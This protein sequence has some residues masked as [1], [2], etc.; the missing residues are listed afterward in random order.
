MKENESVADFNSRT[1]NV[2]NQLKSNGEDYQEQR[3]VE[4]ILRSLPHKYDNLV[5]TIEEAKDLTT[6]KMDELMGS[7]QTH[8]HRI[9]RSTSSSTQEQAFK[10]QSNSKGRGRGRNGSGR[11]SRGRGRGNG[12]QR[13]IAAEISGRAD[14][15]SSSQNTSRGGKKNYNSNMRNVECYYCH[16]Y[17][18]YASDC[19]K[20]QSDQ[21]RQANVAD[22][23]HDAAFI[24]C[25]VGEE[26]SPEV[27]YLDS[28]CSNHMSGNETLFSFIDKSFKSEIKMGNNGTLPVVA[29]DLLWSAPREVKG[30]KYEMCIS[31]LV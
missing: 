10:A 4:K 15:A 6:L 8:E 30:R 25:N 20:K 1:S 9:N 7:L 26:G 19:W 3:I 2:I 28:G 21:S 18:H 11:N 16:K 12:G 23:N 24:M 13:N 22:V 31:P 5:M 27:W 29:K 17:G 14:G